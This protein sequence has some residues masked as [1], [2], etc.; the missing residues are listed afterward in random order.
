M[1]CKLITWWPMC[2][3]R[4]PL[5]HNTARDFR[6]CHHKTRL[7]RHTPKKC[8]A[9][10]DVG[11]Y[12]CLAEKSRRSKTDIQKRSPLALVRNKKCTIPS[13]NLWLLGFNR[14][15]FHGSRNTHITQPL[16]FALGKM[17]FIGLTS[18]RWINKQ[19][20][21]SPYADYKEIP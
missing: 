6:K 1:K 20:T 15:L 10:A 12:W 3:A 5:K 16:L 11:W 8:R 2:F 17:Y 14:A 7:P 19:H 9:M 13:G 18:R 21:I 4:P